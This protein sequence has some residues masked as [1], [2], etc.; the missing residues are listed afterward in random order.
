[1][2]FS[3]LTTFEQS[4]DDTNFA[5]YEGENG[6]KIGDENYLTDYNKMKAIGILATD[7]PA[8][9][10]LASRF[11]E[12]NSSRVSFSMRYVGRGGYLDRDYLCYVNSNANTFYYSTSSYAVRPVV[13]LSSG[14]LGDVAEG[15]GTRTNPIEL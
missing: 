8:D 6:L 10:W 4:V 7:T 1:M 14:A 11:V 15:V 2:D 5:Q 13:T 12:E 9:Y 3:E